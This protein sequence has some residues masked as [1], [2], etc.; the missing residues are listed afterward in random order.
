MKFGCCAGVESMPVLEEAGYDYVE[1]SVVGLNPEGSGK[2]FKELKNRILSHRLRPEA[3]NVFLPGDLK[4]VG[5]DADLTR[6]AHYADLAF[7]R[8]KELGGEI[9][10]FGS[11][12][13]RHSGRICGKRG[14]RSDGEVS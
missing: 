8:V 13:S 9:V 10:V 11:G 4:I 14:S 6:A 1:L 5:A 7:R 3:F 2:E 12:G